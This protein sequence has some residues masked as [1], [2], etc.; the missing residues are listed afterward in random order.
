[1]HAKCLGN[2]L[3]PQV[4]L[5]VN[6]WSLCPITQDPV[7]WLKNLINKFML[8]GQERRDQGVQ[9]CQLSDSH[10]KR[11]LH[12]SQREMTINGI[13]WSWQATGDF[14]QMVH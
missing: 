4:F 1:M 12:R 8:K 5:H 14:I 13:S 6:I 7:T 11:G 10:F 3:Y 2:I 9:L